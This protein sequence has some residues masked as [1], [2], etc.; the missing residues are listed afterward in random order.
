MNFLSHLWF[1]DWS[2]LDYASNAFPNSKIMFTIRTTFN[3]KEFI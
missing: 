3:V 2:M 1:Q